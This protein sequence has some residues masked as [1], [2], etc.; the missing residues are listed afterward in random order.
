[1]AESEK[2]KDNNYQWSVVIERSME[3]VDGRVKEEREKGRMER[4][5]REQIHTRL[6]GPLVDG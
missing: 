6:M 1:M 5:E 4:R 3:G 2:I